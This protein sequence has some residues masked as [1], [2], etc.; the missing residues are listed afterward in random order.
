MLLDFINNT[1]GT[2]K[3]YYL[4]VI[5]GEGKVHFAN[6]HLVT[7]M[8]FQY[9][10]KTEHNFFHLL[11]E[12]GLDSFKTVLQVVKETNKTS[13][14]ELALRNSSI[15]WVK[16]LVSNYSHGQADKFFCIGYDIL[17]KNKVKKLHQ[18]TQAHYES[19]MEGLTLGV[20]LQDEN[21]EIL[22]ANKKAAELTGT[23]IEELYDVN[24]FKNLWK[25]ICASGKSV[26]VEES[27]PMKS[28]RTGA[29]QND[30][31]IKLSAKDGGCKILLMNSQPLFE[32]NEYAASSVVTSLTD[33]T[34]EENLEDEVKQKQILFETFN[35]NSPNLA[36][37]VDENA[38]LLYGNKSFF[39]Y[40]G[41]SENVLGKDLLTLIPAFIVKTFE[42]KHR[43][44][45]G[46]GSP[47][48]TE[49]KLFLSDGSV[50]IFWISLF[51]ITN[52]T[53]KKII[54]GEAI[55]ITERYRAEQKLK[56][57]NERLNYLSH[58]T[59]D[60]IWEWDM[61]SGKIFRNQILQDIIGFTLRNSSN[62]GWWFRRVHPDDRRRLRNE[63]KKA[64]DQ[65][66]QSWE[67]EY[68][69]KN[70]SGNYII[71]YDRGFVIYDKDTPVKMIGS[72]HDVTELKEL[73]AKL[74]EEKIQHQKNITE[75]IFTV[76]EKERTRIGHELH[77][78]VNQILS[79]SKLF[80]DIIKTATAEDQ[81][82]KQKV[83]DYVLSAIEEIRRLSK[84]MVTPQ[85]KEKGLI[86]SVK[87]LVADVNITR[88]LQVC[89]AHD[90]DI[91]IL[92]NGKKVTFFRILQEQLK[93]TLKYSQATKLV[94]SLSVQNKD[95]ILKIEDDGVGFDPN[96]TPRGIGLS[97][98]Y[99]RTNFYNG[100]V[101]INTAPGRGCSL[102]VKIPLMN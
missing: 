59:T 81:A 44:V 10:K 13:Y 34:R 73:E 102:T 76:Q 91:E 12:P 42:Q 24:G 2:D 83:T 96:Q 62:L 80:L 35:D 21:G 18:V 90:D 53:G 60:A 23:S 48:R 26:P 84:E 41:L 66:S 85:L 64:I 45:L 78:N 58:I 52:I 14:L 69:F 79:A 82:L 92:S 39:N 5:D 65:K 15:H 99:E 25:S 97:N 70:A 31:R 93:N 40:L 55:N 89:F 98:I 61:V 68:R 74:V 49:E 100:K 3:D 87:A 43:Q 75:T 36:W 72:M 38:K 16:W 86:Q 46:T 1:N 8:G 57:V 33:I 28:L 77:D 101:L 9:D 6:S 63:I 56:Q 47:L 20:I 94:I 51:P 7:N 54:G 4:M 50:M 30:V 27:P 88:V 95:A 19:I 11:D 32:E 17:G 22:A 67:S 29:M 37:M 71:V